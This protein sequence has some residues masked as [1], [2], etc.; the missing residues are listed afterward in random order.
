MKTGIIYPKSRIRVNATLEGE[1]LE[2][3]LRKMLAGKEPIQ[4]TA[5]INYTDRKDGVLQQ[6]DI[7][8]DRFELALMASDKVHASQYAS[9]MQEDGYKLDENG[10]WV[11]N[12][13]QEPEQPQA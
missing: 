9:R 5:K 12:T 4:A 6:Y 8:T 11:L 1:S 3:T 2:E 7:R 13:T 10:N